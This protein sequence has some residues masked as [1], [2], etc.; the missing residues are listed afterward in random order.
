MKRFATA[1]AAVVAVGALAT[2]ASAGEVTGTGKSTP[3]RDHVAASICAYSGLDD[4]DVEDDAF[5]DRTQN[6]G[7]LARQGLASP[8]EFNPGD[9]CN[10]TAGGHE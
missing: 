3:I 7:Q 4:D 5:F 10:P 2:P 1:A 6:Y 9:A 8:S